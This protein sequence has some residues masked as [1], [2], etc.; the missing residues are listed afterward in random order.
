MSFRW[1][2][3]TSLAHMELPPGSDSRNLRLS[4]EF[5]NVSNTRVRH[6]YNGFFITYAS[7]IIRRNN[8]RTK[9]TH[10]QNNTL[11]IFT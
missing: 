6:N 3:F 4:S 11:M 7:K 5:R 1:D 2:E 10:L 8:V 9:Q